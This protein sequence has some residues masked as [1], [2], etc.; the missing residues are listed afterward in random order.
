MCSLVN[1]VYIAL[2]YK[3]FDKNLFSIR[4]IYVKSEEG[5]AGLCLPVAYLKPLHVYQDGAEPAAA[6]QC[7]VWRRFCRRRWRAVGSSGG[8]A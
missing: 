2:L 4:V 7:H 5:L 8:S 1:V 6:D 3:S